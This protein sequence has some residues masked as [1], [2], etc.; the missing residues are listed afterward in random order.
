MRT[1]LPKA[2]FSSCYITSTPL[3]CFTCIYCALS[4]WMW[5]WTLKTYVSPSYCMPRE[6]RAFSSIDFEA[7]QHA[8]SFSGCPLLRATAL[9]SVH[10]SLRAVDTSI[11]SMQVRHAASERTLPSTVMTFICWFARFSDSHIKYKYMTLNFSVLRSSL[12]TQLRDRSLTLTVGLVSSD[13][14]CVA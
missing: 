14:K 6:I 9:L 7:L 11:I 5:A 4:G 3:A 1:V 10:V 8:L 12:L 13:Q 2:P